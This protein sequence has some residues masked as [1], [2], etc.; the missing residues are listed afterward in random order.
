M[1]TEKHKQIT[2]DI[3]AYRLLNTIKKELNK[4]GM[5]ASYSDAIRHLE[6][7]EHGRN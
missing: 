7:R 4:K 6:W 3:N 1:N 5:R 2:I